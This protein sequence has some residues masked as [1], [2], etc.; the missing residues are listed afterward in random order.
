MGK[1]GIGLGLAACVEG[2]RVT[3]VRDSTFMGSG[4]QNFQ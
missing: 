3:E 2:L 1:A 4:W